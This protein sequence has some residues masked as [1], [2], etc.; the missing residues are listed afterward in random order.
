[1]VQ[2]GVL[3][4]CAGVG[5]GGCIVVNELDAEVDVS[6]LSGGS[7]KVEMCCGDFCVMSS[8]D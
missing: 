3:V 2:E 8:A 4:C 7:A 6:R 5:E 1:V